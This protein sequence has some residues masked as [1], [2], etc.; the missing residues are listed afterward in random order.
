VAYSPTPQPTP[1]AQVVGITTAT[2]FVAANG[3][4][5][6]TLEG[7]QV[8]DVKQPLNNAGVPTHGGTSVQAISTGSASADP[9][10]T[11][12]KSYTFVLVGDPTGQGTKKIHFLAFPNVFTPTPLGQEP[13]PRAARRTGGA[14][15]SPPTA[16]RSP[17]RRWRL[18]PRSDRH[19]G[20]VQ[21]N[22]DAVNVGIGAP[23][24]ATFWKRQVFC[25]GSKVKLYGLVRRP[26]SVEQKRSPAP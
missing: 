13:V 4:V 25:F 1:I 17:R 14:P 24:A 19:C 9:Y 6:P 26:P 5:N 23:S 22:S 12:G 2:G 8:S 20:R 16:S 21:P 10:I 11:V 15:A 3:D 18:S 7:S